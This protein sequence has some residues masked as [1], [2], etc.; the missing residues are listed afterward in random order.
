MHAFCGDGTH[1]H[2]V[3]ATNVQNP[4][5]SEEKQNH[6]YSKLQLF[7][8]CSCQFIRAMQML[9][10]SRSKHASV[11]K[12]RVWENMLSS[13]NVRSCA[14]ACIDSCMFIIGYTTKSMC[15]TT[16][17]GSM[18]VK[19]IAITNKQSEPCSDLVTVSRDQKFFCSEH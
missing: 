12:G 11:Q 5:N 14:I 2:V 4:T 19:I 18:E 6:I 16:L 15:D 13:T 10:N 7:A 9:K 8:P 17:R 3:L 1:S